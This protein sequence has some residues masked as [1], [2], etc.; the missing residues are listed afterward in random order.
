MVPVMEMSVCIHEIQSVFAIY[1]EISR[2]NMNYA[3]LFPD[4]IKKPLTTH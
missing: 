3:V 4:H 1:I 2:Q